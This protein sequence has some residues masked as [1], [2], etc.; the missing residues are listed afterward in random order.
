TYHLMLR[1]TAER[2]A[3]LGGLHAFMRWD[4]PILT[5]SGGFQVMSLSNI[6]QV[7]EEAVTFQSHI[8]GSRHV[9]SPERSIEIQA[10]LLGSDIVMQ[11]DELVALPATETEV[12]E[13]MRRSARWGA[14][15]KAAFGARERQ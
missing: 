3:R 1:P 11:L 12:G 8:D 15:S 6:S 13:A 10:D 4:G 7:R 9:L 5:D 14:R 2:I